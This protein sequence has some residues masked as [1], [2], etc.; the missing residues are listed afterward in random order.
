MD[1]VLVFPSNSGTIIATKTLKESGV[2]ARMIPTPRSV[3]S[4]SNLCLSIDASV[5]GRAV[6]V[7]KAANVSVSAVYR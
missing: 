6:S 1:V 2:P 7:L 4:L 3:Q 5:E